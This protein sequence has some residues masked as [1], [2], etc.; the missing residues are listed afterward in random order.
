MI[1]IMLNGKIKS[2]ILNQ[3]SST[4]DKYDEIQIEKMQVKEKKT[5]IHPQRGLN[6]R[7]CFKSVLSIKYLLTTV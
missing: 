1:D 5:A 2:F 7:G 6:F 4:P 3:K